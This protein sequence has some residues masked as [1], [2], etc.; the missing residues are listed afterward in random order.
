MV[1]YLIIG[2]SAFL[3][4]ALTF[5]SG[6][7]LGTLLMPVVTIFFPVE[8]AVAVT[9]L[10][11][12]ANNGF[13][14]VLMG[15]H[16]SRDVALRFGLPALLS[17]FAGAWLLQS[18]SATEP[19]VS[20][21]LLGQALTVMPVKLAVGVLI[22]VFVLVELSPRVKDMAFPRSWQPVGGV[23]SG[24][25]GGFSGHQG[26]L[27]SM[28][29]IKAGLGRDA[30]IGTGVVIAVM[31]DLARL[32]VYGAGGTFTRSGIETPLVVTAALAA[33]AGSWLCKRFLHK[34]TFEG[35][36]KLVAALLLLVAAGLITGAL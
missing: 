7:G 2:G 18:L 1:E 3:A 16:A 35:V 15:R 22:A 8:V 12:L 20:Y 4:A 28:F 29:L 24:F 11:H 34:V 17:A 32:G 31:V 27:R 19:L 36:Q 5:F 13:K 25:L 6:F 33:F 26:A 30:F 9:A 21:S 14:L 10:V 23:I